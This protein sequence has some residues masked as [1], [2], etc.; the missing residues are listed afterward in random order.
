MPHGYPIDRHDGPWRAF[1]LNR[2]R[3]LDRNDDRHALL[4][5]E[6]VLV[7]LAFGRD[8]FLLGLAVQVHDVDAVE[9]L[10]QVLAHFQEGRVVEIAVVPRPAS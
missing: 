8:F 3:F 4:D 7:R 1:A 2:G 9:G 6:D 10:H 5:V